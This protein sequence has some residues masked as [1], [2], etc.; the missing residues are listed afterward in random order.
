MC[1]R[2]GSPD[3]ADSVGNGITEDRCIDPSPQGILSNSKS[4]SDKSSLKEDADIGRHIKHTQIVNL[5]SI[6]SPVISKPN[7]QAVRRKRSAA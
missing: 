5:F 2:T 6:T 1:E 7:V 3:R 4:T